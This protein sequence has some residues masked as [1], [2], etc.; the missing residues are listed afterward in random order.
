M[1]APRPNDGAGV[2]GPGTEGDGRP[3]AEPGLF[4]QFL[5]FA[6]DAIVGIDKA[7]GI[8]L[9]NQQ[10]ER[11]FG[12]S[13]AE[14]LGKPVEMLLPERFRD[15]HGGHRAAYF[16]DPRTR[17]MGAG[18]EL[19]GL[20]S[21][22]AEFHAEI[23]LSSIDTGGHPMAIAAVRDMTD[24][25][26]AEREKQ[27]LIARMER[28][29]QREQASR[30]E[31]V[32]QLAGGVAHDFNNLLGVVLNY[33]DFIA[34]EIGEESPAYQDVKEIRRAAER[35]T[36]LTRQLLTFSRREVVKPQPINLNDSVRE[37]ERLLRRT[38]GE[39]VE[40]VVK[41]G[42]DLPP[43]LADPGQLEQV[44]VNLAINARDAMPTGGRLRIETAEVEIDADFLEHKP[45]LS[46]GRYVQLTV[47][48]T[49]TGM[50]EQ[51]LSRVFEPFFSTKPKGEGT[52]LGLATVYGIV[53]GNGGAIS[54]YSELGEGTVFKVHL[55]A[56]EEPV[57]AGSEADAA[58]GPNGG[59][60]HILVVEDEDAV[61]TLANRI[62]TRAGY[63]VTAL[64]RAREAVDLLQN[65]N[66]SGYDLLLT[67][68]VMPE[69]RGVELVGA[70]A[71]IAPELPVLMMSGYS[72]PMF[73]EERQMIARV[74]LLEK[75][76]S[77]STLLSQVRELLDARKSA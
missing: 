31:S 13:R 19:Y 4:E 43:V 15:Q 6:P 42:R 9:V 77:G 60:E 16:D 53:R 47:A 71:E 25:V 72:T 10:T 73:E 11:L 66:G 27:E 61:R 12:Y 2:R 74:P 67:D 69:M 35:A 18:L 33:A 62:L 37:M 55:P 57:S 34:E 65:G 70:A 28:E 59:G 56:I 21:D 75:P 68:V 32:G 49:G 3:V 14:L 7:G 1:H 58:E 36:Q 64:S 23:S 30:L 20:R 8:A 51:T 22:G 76:F 52:G 5:D 40:L 48:D 45:D 39:H 50:D 63:E 46:L 29:Q 26:E 24:R 38:L 17:P 54:I 41:F 44:L